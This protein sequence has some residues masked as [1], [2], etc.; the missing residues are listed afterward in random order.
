ML[1]DNDT[2]MAGGPQVDMFML[3]NEHLK[4]RYNLSIPNRYE[5]LAIEDGFQLT[6][7]G[8]CF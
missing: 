8:E 7:D 2:E 5:I 3:R 6:E 1:K 4:D